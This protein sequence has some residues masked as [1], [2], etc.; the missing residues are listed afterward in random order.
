M[1]AIRRKPAIKHTDVIEKLNSLIVTNFET[2]TNYFAVMILETRE[3]HK[4]V[5]LKQILLA[6]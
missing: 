3:R 1:K 4:K 6:L 2:R 5:F